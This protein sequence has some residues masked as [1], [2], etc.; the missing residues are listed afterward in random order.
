MFKY[1]LFNQ[2][3][4]GCNQHSSSYRRKVLTGMRA[5]FTSAATK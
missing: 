3:P 4:Y 1:R 5:A 2:M